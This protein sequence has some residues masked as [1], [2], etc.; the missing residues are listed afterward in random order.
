VDLLD[1]AGTCQRIQA[2]I[3][4]RHGGD[5]VQ[6]AGGVARQ[7]VT[8]N[9]EM[10]VMAQRDPVFAALIQR[11][12]LVTADGVGLLWAARLRGE[13]LPERV[14]G[15][16]LLV[17]LAAL[18]AGAGYRLFLLGGAPGVAEAAGQALH[19]R[20]P[21]LPLAGTY[22]GS[23]GEADDEEALRRI[24][25]ARPD[26][27]FVAYGAPAQERWIA[28]H[29]EALGG[30]VAVGVG[31]ALDFLAGRVPRAPA[32]MRTRGLEWLYRLW[33]EPWRWRRMVALPRFAAL[34]GWEALTTRRHDRLF[35][36]SPFE[37]R[38][39]GMRGHG[40]RE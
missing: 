18:A 31:G 12:D 8:L 9:P 20:F 24:H 23:P 2:W 17:A 16:D 22:T 37:A 5:V 32:W 33:R 29:R 27:L 3:A 36:T 15:V 34:A 26:L 7:V 4:A 25:A 30:V 39:Q 14:T 1:L 10:V 6:G 19:A 13:R 11:A 38:N 40:E 35:D 21:G 28:R